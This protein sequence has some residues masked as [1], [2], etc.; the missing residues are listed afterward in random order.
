M[1]WKSIVWGRDLFKEGYCWRVGKGKYIYID[2]DLWMSREGKIFPLKTPECLKRTRVEVLF[3]ELGEWNAPLIER[4]FCPSNVEDILCISRGR[5]T[6]KDEIFWPLDTK[7]I[8]NIKSAYHLACKLALAQEASSSDLT[9]QRKEWRKI[10]KLNIIPRA[11]ICICKI[12]NNYIPSKQNIIQ[13][14]WILTHIVLY[15][16]GQRNLWRMRCGNAK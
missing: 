16:G 10:W 8:F 12:I 15:A 3:D 14:E 7:G 6:S 9:D 2:Q 11:K 4:F 13:K 1:V 5:R